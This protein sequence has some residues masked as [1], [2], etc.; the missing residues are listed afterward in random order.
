MKP[1]QG[2]RWSDKESDNLLWALY[3]GRTI[4]WC[5]RYYGRTEKEI[6]MQLARLETTVKEVPCSSQP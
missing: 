6:A 1:R 4:A 2:Y 5:A 3:A